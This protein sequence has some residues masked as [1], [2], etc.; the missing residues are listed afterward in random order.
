MVKCKEKP[1]L[2]NHKYGPRDNT[3]VNMDVI[4]RAE[5]GRER[6][7]PD[8][9]GIPTINFFREGKLTYQWMFEKNEEALRD[10]CFERITNE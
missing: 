7:Y 10:S 2:N 5:K 4:E 1:H 8:N 9:E 3:P 6:Y